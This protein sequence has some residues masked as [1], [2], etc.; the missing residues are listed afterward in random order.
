M[1]TSLAESVES[2]L[3]WGGGGVMVPSVL[4]EVVLEIKDGF[5]PPFA[6]SDAAEFFL[7]TPIGGDVPII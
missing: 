7:S 6:Y 1:L 3:I 5:R 2:F 4:P